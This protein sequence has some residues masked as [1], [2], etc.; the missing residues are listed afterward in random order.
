MKTVIL[1]IV[2]GAVGIVLVLV[3][4]H[5]YRDHAEFD[6]IRDAI[7]KSALAAKSALPMTEPK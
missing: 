4:L 3:G 5:L 1:A 2:G 6:K 7:V